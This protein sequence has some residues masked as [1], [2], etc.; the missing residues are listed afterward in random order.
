M[1]QLRTLLIDCRIELRKLVREFHKTELCERLDVAVQSLANA[2]AVEIDLKS[3]TPPTAS[4]VREIKETSN[5]VALAWQMAARD[6]KFSNPALYDAMSK[7]VMSRLGTKT[8]V[9]QVDELKQ[10]EDAAIELKEEAAR[11]EKDKQAMEIERDTLLGALASAVPELADGGDKLGV[12]LAR[13][14]WL[15][16]QLAK[17]G[18]GQRSNAAVANEEENRVPSAEILKVVAA[19]AR[20]FTNAQREWCVGEA[21]VLSGFQLTPMELI[22]QGDAKIA[23]IISDAQLGH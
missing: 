22:E 10:L 9:D 19:G 17:G 23:K 8:L 20:K 6:L 5:Q 16:S 4:T 18:G 14:D 3:P 13:I 7:K 15:K 12:A 11:A 21:M 1:K 2:E